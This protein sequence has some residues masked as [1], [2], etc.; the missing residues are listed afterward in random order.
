[1]T[2]SEGEGKKGGKRNRQCQ[3][4]FLRGAQ[5]LL[6]LELARLE[7][8]K[9]DEEDDRRQLTYAGYRYCWGWGGVCKGTAGQQRQ[10][11]RY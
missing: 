11:P 6:T 4:G 1:M 2:A 7:R 8:K 3:V 5:K 10:N 9:L